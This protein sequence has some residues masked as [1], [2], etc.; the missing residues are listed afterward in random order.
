VTD[1]PYT[2]EELATG[3]FE[4]NA[5]THRERAPYKVG[6]CLDFAGGTQLARDFYDG[7]Q[8]A[9]DEAVER[10]DVDHPVELVVREVEGPMRGTSPAVVSA[11]RELAHEEDCLVILGPVVTEANLAIVDEVNASR[12]PTISFCASFDWA[13]PYCY[14]LQNGGFPD[15]ANVL[16]A[17]MAHEGLQ[18]VA[19]FHEDGLIGEEFLRAFKAA[20]RRHGLQIVGEHTVGLFNTLRPVEPQLAASR[21][22]GAEAI[23]VLSA[24]GALAPVQRALAAVEDTWGWHPARYQNMTWVAMTALGTIGDYDLDALLASNEGWIGLDQIHE[25]NAHFQAVLD[26]FEDRHHRRPFHSYTALG[27][28]H[29]LVVSDALSR[30]KPPSREGFKDALERLRM[31]PSCIGSPGTVIS[32]APHDNRGYKGDYIILR[33]VED[34]IERRIDLSMVDLLRVTPPAE[35]AAVVDDDTLLG[36]GSRYSL[37]GHRTPFK[38]GVL[39]D[40]ALWA[41]LPLWYNGLRLAFD[42]AFESGLLDRSVELVIEEVEGPPERDAASVI[43]A[44]HRLVEHHQVLAVVGPFITDMVRILRDQIEQDQVPIVTYAATVKASG[45][46]VFQTP[47]GTFADETFHTARYLRRRGATSVGIVRED[48]PIGDEYADFFRQH[49]RR[50]GLSV[51]SDQ[52]VSGHATRGEM[53]RAMTALRDAGA[54]SVMHLGYG[55]TFFEILTVM[56]ELRE[57]VGWDPPRATITTWV[58]ASGLGEEGGSPYLLNQPLREALFEGWVGVD[59]P[60]EGNQV[61]TGFMERY[62][63]RYGGARP[64]GCYPA[65][66]Y[67]IGRTLAEAIAAARPVNPRGVKGGLEQVRM[68]PAAMGAPGTVIGFAPYDHRGYKGDYLVLRG[69]RDGVEGLAEQ[70]FADALVHD[71]G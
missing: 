69:Y 59:L 2:A 53:R 41:R 23:V 11:W 62:V 63:K 5:V 44:W 12:V 64:F 35:L 4:R 48:N 9:I 24:Y 56:Q 38:V 16:A 8:L 28:D 15:E 13:G 33:T 7:I 46:Y 6:I 42:E 20:T 54:E 43:R 30:M 29:G 1:G 32:F 25:G 14:A 57:R 21:A 19:V 55:L 51:A 70:L 58:L 40:W 60:H 10:G 37:V 47:N 50:V 52:I 66:M 3:E 26:R 49:A 34:G 71:V 68:L 31:R 27:F 45:D 65:H 22:A 17:H 36:A 61:F 39:Q 18:K 67:D